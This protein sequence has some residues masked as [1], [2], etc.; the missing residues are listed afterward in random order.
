[1]AVLKRDAIGNADVWLV[2][3]RRGILTR[4][5]THPKE[6]VFPVWSH[7]GSRIA[8]QSNRDGTFGLYQ[9]GTTGVASEELLLNLG[10]VGSIANDWSPDGQFLLYQTYAGGTGADLWVLPL[11][12]G[13][14]SLPVI[15]T[16]SDERD[17][18]FSPD[19]K[20]IAYRPTVLDGSRCTYSRFPARAPRYKCLPAVV[21]RCAGGPMGARCSTLART[22]ASRRSRFRSLGTASPSVGVP[23]ALFTARVG[24]FANPAEPGAQYV[25]SPD[26]QSFLMNT[27]EAAGPTPVRL[28]LNWK[29]KP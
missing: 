2:E 22:D 8:F 11:R 19:G 13:G 9:K 14:K 25:V 24:H 3:T 10:D 15:H 20:W 28:I 12:G 1:M 29:P 17:G 16:E 7:D 4:F 27:V 23:V 6:D 5:T 18:Q 26:G 21:R